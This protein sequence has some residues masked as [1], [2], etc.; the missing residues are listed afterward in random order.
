M[1]L[2]KAAIAASSAFI[3]LKLMASVIE[4]EEIATVTS[5]LLSYLEGQDSRVAEGIVLP[6][7]ICKK[8]LEVTAKG[9]F[10]QE[11]RAYVK[12]VLLPYHKKTTLNHQPSTIPSSK[13]CYTGLLR[14]QSRRNKSQSRELC[15]VL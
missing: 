4:A 12:D 14:G 9:H 11:V 1:V 6:L 2:T 8:M 3:S 13:S 15:P 7:I 5:G 10:W